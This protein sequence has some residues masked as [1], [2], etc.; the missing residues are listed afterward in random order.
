MV[1]H[2]ANVPVRATG[3]V[4][5]FTQR[6]ARGVTRL[7]GWKVPAWELPDDLKKVVV[8]GEHHTSNMDGFLMV[9]L[10]ASMGRR[11][12]WLVKTELDQPIIGDMIRAS[13]GIFVNRHHPNGTVGHVV[14]IIEHSDSIF[15]TLAPSSTRSYTDRWRTGFYYMADGANVPVALGFLDY[16]NKEAGIGKVIHLSGDMAQDEPIFQDFYKDITA[17]FPEKTSEV[18]LVPREG[19]SD[20]TD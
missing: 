20:A 18:R 15:L 5:K 8:I 12:S 16:A 7:I 10:V 9:L 11:L 2:F 17:R 13:G 14:E 4:S 19:Q 6:L 3:E 1:E